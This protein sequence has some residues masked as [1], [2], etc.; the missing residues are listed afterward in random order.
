MD[1]KKTVIGAMPQD[2][3]E[4]AKAMLEE[5]AKEGDTAGYFYVVKVTNKG[6]D[7]AEIHTLGR[8]YKVNRELILDN[9][10]RALDMNPLELLEY[11]KLKAQQG[12]MD[13]FPTNE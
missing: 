4:E 11:I 7:R 13:D 10:L 2:S 12:Q 3:V 1:E 5:I 8:V 6:N 9:T